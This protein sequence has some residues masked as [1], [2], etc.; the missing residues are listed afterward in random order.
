MNQH[1]WAPFALVQ[2]PDKEEGKQL[3]K[4]W[5]LEAQ[6]Y[7]ASF[8][9]DFSAHNHRVGLEILPRRGHLG[10]CQDFSQVFLRKGLLLKSSA[11]DVW[12]FISLIVSV[13]DGLPSKRSL[14]SQITNAFHDRVWL[15][16]FLSF[17]CFPLAKCSS[18]SSKLKLEAKRSVNFPAS[19]IEN[20]L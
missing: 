11:T 7:K 20:D 5:A 18:K 12:A 2:I 6:G 10:C 19:D 1:S 9:L 16:R 8:F 3:T 17:P 14:L 15:P 4:E 13:I